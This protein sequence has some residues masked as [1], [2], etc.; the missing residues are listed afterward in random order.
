[1]GLNPDWSWSV[2]SR[3]AKITHK[4]RKKGR[5]EGDL[6][7]IGGAYILVL[8]RNGANLAHFLRQIP[9]RQK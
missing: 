8:I 7:F 2:G 1:V 6:Y 5:K 9:M 3:R 4:C